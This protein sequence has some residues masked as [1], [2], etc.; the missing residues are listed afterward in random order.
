MSSLLMA[1]E[2]PCELEDVLNEPE[3]LRYSRHLLLGEVGAAGQLRLKRARVLIVGMGGLGS[4]AGLYLAAAG[5]GRLGLVD[6]DRVDHSNLHRQVLYGE[7][8]VGRDK[9]E[10]AADA[11]RR[12]N[13]H[14]EVIA[15]P[16]RLCAANALDLVSGYDLVIDGTDNFPTRYA[17]NDA[18]AL[19]GKPYVYGSIHHFEGQAAVFDARRGPCYRCLFPA[20]PPPGAIPTCAE[21]GVLGV[22]PGVIGMIQAAEAIKRILGIGEPLIGRVL[23]FDALAMSFQ[24]LRLAKDPACPLCGANPSVSRVEEIAMTCSGAQGDVV[25]VCE[26]I[27]RA[28]LTFLLESGADI[29]LI[30]VRQP[31]ETANGTIPGALLIPLDQLQQRIG[32]VD[33]AAALVVYCA[34][35]VRSRRAAGLLEQAGFKRVRSLAGGYSAWQER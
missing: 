9:T 28:E 11:L 32:E 21:A 6:A 14:I 7:G 17:L 15:Y 33:S 2:I 16:Q 34:A 30:D 27:D 26:E 3:R 19:T 8:D 24:T 18:C 4:P 1:P 5:A 35:G 13:P 12:A 29:T 25:P 31:H 23:T 10:A 22:L 20:P